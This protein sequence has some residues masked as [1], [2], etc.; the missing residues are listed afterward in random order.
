MTAKANNADSAIIRRFPRQQIKLPVLIATAGNAEIA[1]SGLATEISRRGMALYGGIHLQPGELMEVEFPTADHIR[2]TG[3][4]RNRTGYW[5]GLEFVSPEN[6]LSSTAGP[7]HL[8]MGGRAEWPGTGEV[9]L[10]ERSHEAYRQRQELEI[11]YLRRKTMRMRQLRQKIEA[12]TQER[13]SAGGVVRKS[14][15]ALRKRR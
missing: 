4:I 8:G 9:S 11:E 10:I 7:S 6:A 15:P 12:L 2:V 3:I 14:E 1:V 13:P 5:F